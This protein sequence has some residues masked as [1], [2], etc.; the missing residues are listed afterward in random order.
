MWNLAKKWLFN[1]LRLGIVIV[2]II[3]LEFG[4][5][6][7]AANYY[8]HTEQFYDDIN[9]DVL[10]A[11]HDYLWECTNETMY[12]HVSN[13]EK[14]NGIYVFNE[15]CDIN[16]SKAHFCGWKKWVKVE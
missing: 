16:I 1:P 6:L 8:V 9:P 15:K 3:I 5:A 10:M 7:L 2:L 14:Y 4:I 13:C 11:T 12:S